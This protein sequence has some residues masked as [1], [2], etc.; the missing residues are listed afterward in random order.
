MHHLICF[1]L[2]ICI[3][4]ARSNPT[5]VADFLDDVTNIVMLTKYF[6][7]DNNIIRAQSMIIN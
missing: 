3:I 5:T 6:E 4:Y 1:F 2:I 7:A